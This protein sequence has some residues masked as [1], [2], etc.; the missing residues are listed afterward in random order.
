MLA[1]GLKSKCAITFATPSFVKQVV[2]T[3]PRKRASCLLAAM[4]TLLET[5]CAAP[6]ILAHR[7]W[8]KMSLGPNYGLSYVL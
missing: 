5:V 4:D 7:L 1:F 6:I 3:V 2:C 8:R